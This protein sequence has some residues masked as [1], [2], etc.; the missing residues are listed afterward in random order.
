MPT[1]RTVLIT[2]CS[3]GIGLCVARGLWS[4]GY[5]VIATARK[6]KDV[7]QLTDEGFD[8]LLLDLDDSE[9]IRQSVAEAI[10]PQGLYALFNNGAWGLPGTVEDLSRG[11][12][13]AS[14]FALEGI[15]DTQRMELRNTGAHISLTDPGPI[16][17][18]F[19]EN[20]Y[21]MYQRWTGRDNSHHRAQYEAM[22]QRLLKGG[23]AVPFTLRP[24]AVLAQGASTR[25]R[26]DDQRSGTTSR[27]LPTCS[28]RCSVGCPAAY[29][30]DC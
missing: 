9:S 16:E 13:T 4:L 7:Y 20:A 5:H 25:W 26:T 24:E 23:P 3:S 15:T 8:A 21:R 30:I 22:E 19:R 6:A 17:S 14:K 10:A 12:Y 18:R 28:A 2:G 29:W 27:F 1:T 11:A